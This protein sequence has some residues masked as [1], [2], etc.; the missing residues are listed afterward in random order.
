MKKLGVTLKKSKIGSPYVIA[1]ME[2]LRTGNER[3]AP[4]RV[5]GWEANGGFLLGTSVA[6]G[7]GELSA[8]PTRDSL[9]PILVNLFAANREG[10][11]L[12]AL[13]D[14]LPA[15]F[16]RAGLI[17]DVAAAVSRALFGR[18]IPPV[19][20]I[21]WQL[22]GE[23]ALTGP[24]RGIKATIEK[25]FTPDLGFDQVTRVNVMDGV[26]I[27]FQ[28]GD[29]AHLRAS[30]NAPQLRAYANSNSQARADEI[31]EVTLRE[32]DGIVRR[33]QKAFA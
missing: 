2:S 12:A 7:D 27:H 11:S 25:F 8:L 31:V 28:N 23:V 22:D 4:S 18:L 16:G 10:I 24:G 14:R 19:A 26:R 13:W 5:M 32:P 29:V 6:F 30:G 33:M 15:R 3:G 1:G 20:K 17:D 9:L 21:D